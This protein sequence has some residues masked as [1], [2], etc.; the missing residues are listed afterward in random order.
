MSRTG[1]FS[2]ATMMVSAQRRHA[3]RLAAQEAARIVPPAPPAAPPRAASAPAPGPRGP[4]P[5]LQLA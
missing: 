3:A 1:G 4:A 5:W 2:F